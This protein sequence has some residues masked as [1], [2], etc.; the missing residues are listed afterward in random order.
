[1]SVRRKEFFGKMGVPRMPEERSLQKSGRRMLYLPLRRRNGVLGKRRNRL[2]VK[3]SEKEKD[4]LPERRE[5]KT[6]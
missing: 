3:G 2:R 6:R 4:K 5:K 1:M